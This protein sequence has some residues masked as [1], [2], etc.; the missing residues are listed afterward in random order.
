ML[1]GCGGVRRICI[2]IGVSL[3]I[4]SSAFG[5]RLNRTRLLEETLSKTGRRYLQLVTFL[6]NF[7]P[8]WRIKLVRVF[9]H[10]G[11]RV[12]M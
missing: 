3:G 12:F 7:R 5:I 9:Q 4:K 11:I 8:V 2:D 1:L 10:S 6:Q